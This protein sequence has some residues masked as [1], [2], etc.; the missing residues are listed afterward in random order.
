MT[1]A[2]AKL[3][4][5]EIAA[6]EAYES[7]RMIAG[8]GDYILLDSNENP[9]SGEGLLLGLNRHPEPQPA[10]LLELMAD[11]YRVGQAQVMVTRG[12][13]EGIEL[14]INAFCVPGQDKVLIAS[15]TFTYYDVVA[16]MQGAE[17]IHVPLGEGF[18]LDTEAVLAAARQLKPKL[19]FLCSPNNPSGNDLDRGH[20]M[21]LVAALPDTI[22]VID[23]AYSEFTDKASLAP[24]I[25]GN[26]NIVVLRTLSK[27]FA[28]AGA[29]CGALLA[30]A[31]LIK[32]LL[33]V[34]APYPVSTLV[35][36]AATSAMGPEGMAR[37][38]DSVGR[39]IESRA[40]LAI[41]LE[42]MDGV[43]HVYPS[44][45][46]FL[47]VRFD[48][49]A[50]VMARVKARGV[51]IRDMSHMVPDCIRISIGSEDELAALVVALS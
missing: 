47:L 2:L 41:T 44:S 23:E 46:N 32:V 22:I 11:F 9:Y 26:P 34:L 17:P 28:L 36:D 25:A 4:R 19:I 5:P 12:S 18:A 21:D 15:P 39:I 38:T 33:G 31:A 27:A 45:T 51:L 3:L 37:M 40:E 35:A 7:A 42:G 6:L 48:D 30:D 43:T 8:S 24:E 49:C 20:M 1:Y 14:L 10:R 29:R 16:R 13:D 50:A